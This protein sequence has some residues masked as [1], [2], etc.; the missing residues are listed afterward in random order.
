LVYH[1][2]SGTSGNVRRISIT[3]FPLS[4]SFVPLTYPYFSANVK[5]ASGTLEAPTSEVISNVPPLIVIVPL[6][7]P[8]SPSGC[9]KIP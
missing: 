6:I 8:V 3:T 9:T 4:A 5:L 1:A 7:F 2:S